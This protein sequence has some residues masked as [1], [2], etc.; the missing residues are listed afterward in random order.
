MANTE[1]RVM[2]DRKRIRSGQGDSLRR[3]LALFLLLTALVA[4]YAALSRD[5][6]W[7]ER[8]R[9]SRLQG[10]T[11]YH[12]GNYQT[13]RTLYET[14]LADNPYDWETRLALA[15]I[16]AKNLNAPDDALK[17]YTLALAYSPEPSIVDDTQHQ[18]A[19]LHLLRSGELENP[20]DAIEDMFVAIETDAKHLFTRRL[21]LSLRHETDKFWDAWKKRGRGAITNMTIINAH[22]GSYDASLELDF[23]DSTAMSLHLRSPL[24]DLWRLDLSFP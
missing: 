7:E 17:H 5:T 14:A 2:S 23:P 16:L 8:S 22:D 1:P 11:A 6:K 18:T 13:A 19:I 4:A 24:R 9:A 10:D 21:A 12:N 15:N 20:Q 3:W